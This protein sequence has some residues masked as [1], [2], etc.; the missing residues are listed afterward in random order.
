VIGGPVKLRARWSS[1]EPPEAGQFFASARGRWIYRIVDVKRIDPR[2]NVR[3]YGYILTCER[4]LP[5][6]V[7]D[8]A[9]IRPW[10]WDR[11]EKAATK[12]GQNDRRGDKTSPKRP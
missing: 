5:E 4:W 1:A 3:R 10:A 12:I 7:P 6:D 11:R 8:E 9:Q 2:K